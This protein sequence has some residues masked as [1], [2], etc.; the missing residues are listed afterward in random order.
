MHADFIPTWA[1][2]APAARVS[3]DPRMHSKV[4]LDH[5]SRTKPRTERAEDYARRREAQERAAAKQASTLAARRAH[6]EL[7]QLYAQ[8]A[9]NEISC[10]GAPAAV[11][12]RASLRDE[13]VLRA[14]LGEIADTA[15]REG[16]GAPAVV[17]IGDVVDV[18]L[19]DHA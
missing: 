11:V 17:V 19:A 7:A 4:S 9:A 6:Q 13:R 2:H 18:L 5:N 14:P 1:C 12:H 10:L 3:D 15:R 16:V 8:L